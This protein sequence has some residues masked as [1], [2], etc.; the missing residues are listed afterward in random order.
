MDATVTEIHD[1]PLRPAGFAEPLFLGP[2]D[3]K[4]IADH[5]AAGSWLRKAADGARRYPSPCHVYRSD[6]RGGVWLARP[7]CRRTKRRAGK[8]RVVGVIGRWREVSGWWQDGGGEDL[9]LYRLLLS[10]GAVVDVARDRGAGGWELVR[11][12]D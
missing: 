6:A 4:E 12:L 3:K 5:L 2:K 1:H 8:R 7:G 9:L 11:V 10:G